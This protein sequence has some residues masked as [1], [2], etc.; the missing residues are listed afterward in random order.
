MITKITEFLLKDKFIME[1]EPNNIKIL[2]NI[3]NGIGEYASYA[4]GEIAPDIKRA[5]GQEMLDTITKIELN[6]SKTSNAKLY[7]ALAIAYRNYC[8]WFVRGIERKLYLEKTTNYLRLTINTSPNHITSKAELGKLLIEEKAIRNLEEGIKI[9]QD[10]K[11]TKEMPDYLDS[12]LTKA[13]RQNRQIEY[14]ANYNLCHFINPSPAVFKEER[15][16]FRA[17]IKESQKRNDE[18]KLKQI[19]TQYYHLAILVTLCYEGHDCNSAVSGNDY[20]KAKVIVN[21]V[22]QKINYNFSDNGYIENSNFMS[23]NDWKIFEKV[24]GN[25][26]ASLNLNKINI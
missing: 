25:T 17:L 23:E 19:L 22:C 21:R 18:I 1:K 3:S 14:M 6:S 2:E 12:V 10:L 4:F 16:K 7:Y 20:E 24:F 11:S 15:K 5:K 26:T 8:A 13:L 9:L